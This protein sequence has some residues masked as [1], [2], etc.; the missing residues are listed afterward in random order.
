MRIAFITT[1]A[2]LP[3]VRSPRQPLFTHDDQLLADE[4][5]R[6]GH[7]VMPWVWHGPAPRPAPDVALMRSPW[8]YAARPDAF[9]QFLGTLEATGIPV[10]NPLGVIRDNLDKRYLVRLYQAGASVVSTHLI[11][12]GSPDARLHDWISR[13]G[14]PELIVKPVVSGGAYHTYR[15]S[16]AEAEAFQP[17]FDGL[18]SQMD[19]LLQPFI[20]SVLGAGEWS[21]V[22]FGGTY[23]HAVRKTAKPGDFRVQDDWGGTVH[24]DTPPP[25]LLAQAQAL[26]PHVMQPPAPYLRL[27]GLWHEDRFLIMEVELAEPELFFRAHPDAPAR[28]ATVLEAAWT[29]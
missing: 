7:T 16:E 23:S 22:Y 1:D 18:A 13:T 17:T 25:A 6:R 15:V 11:P 3:Y 27:D 12:K 14:W 28:F 21:L 2:L 10:V 4:L 29:S 19:F 9:F 20:P 24:L 5:A 8:D 26:L